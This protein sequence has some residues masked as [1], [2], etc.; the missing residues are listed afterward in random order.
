MDSC[1]TELVGMPTVT[2]VQYRFD[3]LPQKSITTD[4]IDSRLKEQDMD[5]F[6]CEGLLWSLPVIMGAF[7]LPFDGEDTRSYVSVFGKEVVVF[8]LVEV[9]SVGCF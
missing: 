5:Y 1:H 3:H 6:S 2:S 8:S 7:H 9:L 4:I